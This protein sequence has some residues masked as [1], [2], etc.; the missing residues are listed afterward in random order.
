MNFYQF[1]NNLDAWNETCSAWRV[2]KMVI[3]ACG[4][5]VVCWGATKINWRRKL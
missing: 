2:V 1:L 3:T 4:V 5:I